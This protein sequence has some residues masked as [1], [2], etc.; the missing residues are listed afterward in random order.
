MTEVLGH[1]KFLVCC[2]SGVFLLL[3]FSCW[4]EVARS[5][6]VT[7]CLAD[8][9]QAHVYIWE[10]VVL[11]NVDSRNFFWDNDMFPVFVKSIKHYKIPKISLRLWSM[12]CWDLGVCKWHDLGLLSISFA[13][14]EVCYEWSVSDGGFLAF[15]WLP[16]VKCLKAPLPNLG[17]AFET[18]LDFPFKADRQTSRAE[19]R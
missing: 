17:E 10:A 5:W 13:E 19:A 18:D 12:H 1:D 9:S 15:W 6:W 4:K 3:W 8:I 14:W 7:L 16:R 2:D 11:L